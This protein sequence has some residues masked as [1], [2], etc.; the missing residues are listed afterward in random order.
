VDVFLAAAR[1]RH[2]RISNTLHL[3]SYISRHVNYTM[4]K[5]TPADTESDVH[6]PMKDHDDTWA[7]Q[8]GRSRHTAV[9]ERSNA[10][11]HVERPV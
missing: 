2:S 7:R 8:F 3:Y 6:A 4:K 1:R 5:H 11:R 9:S 10:A